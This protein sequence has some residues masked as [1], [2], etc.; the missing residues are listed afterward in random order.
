[1]AV[2]NHE[3]VAALYDRIA[4][5]YDLLTLSFRAL[6]FG[7]Y[8]RRLIGDLGLSAGD[9]V[10]DF[11]CGT[12][13][14]FEG[15]SAAVGPR[16]Q[17]IG[18]DLSDGMLAKARERIQSAGL[19]NVSLIQTDVTD[20]RLPSDTA[21]V[22]STFGLE[23]APTYDDVVRHVADDLSDGGRLGLLGLKHPEGWPEWLVR[24]GIKATASFG[25]SSDYEGFT[26]WLS[27]DE[28]F[29]RRAFDQ[30]FIGAAY[31][32]VGEKDRSGPIAPQRH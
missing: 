15:L 26:P 25:V 9:T 19:Q 20:Y 13:V 1:M 21:A 27:A 22:L 12:G 6:G 11:C 17:V 14:N 18:V 23:M 4:D 8:Q 31:S 7:R 30:H 5:R 24:V 2:L 3:Q 32:Y 10:V 16:G 29:R 28:H